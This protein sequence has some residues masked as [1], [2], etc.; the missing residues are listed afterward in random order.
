MTNLDVENEQNYG[1]NFGSKGS[2]RGQNGIDGI[3]LNIVVK[4]FVT[5]LNQIE[6]LLM[7]GRN[8]FLYGECRA[9]LLFVKENHGGIFRSVIFSSLID[10]Q[11]KF[12]AEQKIRQKNGASTRLEKKVRFE[13]IENLCNFSF[14][15]NF[16]Q[17]TVLPI[18][19]EEKVCRRRTSTPREF[20]RS[21]KE[22]LR[23]SFS[24]RSIFIFTEK[25]FALFSRVQKSTKK[26]RRS[27]VKTNRPDFWTSIWFDPVYFVWIYFS[28]FV[29]PDRCRTLSF[30]TIFFFSFVRRSSNYVQTFFFFSLVRRKRPSSVKPRFCSNAPF[31]CDVVPLDSGPNGSNRTFML[32]VHRRLFRPNRTPIRTSNLIDCTKQ[33]RQECFTFGLKWVRSSIFDHEKVD[34]ASLSNRKLRSFVQFRSDRDERLSE[35]LE[36]RNTRIF[37]WLFELLKLAQTK[38]KRMKRRLSIN[39]TNVKENKTMNSC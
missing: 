14:R 5:R 28:N 37:F 36:E 24:R 35:F 25:L 33:H 19:S 38:V 12:R 2:V 7:N 34:K 32:F 26:T 20:P 31:S 23:V 22:N 11:R 1:N 18:R 9:F 29:H 17:T 8:I 16:R 4:P 13:S 39:W 3:I 27:T 21:S 10:P 15:R 30:S 6:R